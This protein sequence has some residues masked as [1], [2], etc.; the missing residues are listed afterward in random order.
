[1]AKGAR[2]HLVRENLVVAGAARRLLDWPHWALKN[3]YGPVGLMFGKS[4]GRRGAVRPA[5]GPRH[6]QAPAS[7][8]AR[9]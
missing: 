6:Q 5:A 3:P 9:R 4:I 8:A 1:M 2:R 7:R